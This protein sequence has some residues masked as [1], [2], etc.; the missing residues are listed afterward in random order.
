MR[1]PLF[2]GANTARAFSK[3][4]IHFDFSQSRAYWEQLILSI[5]RTIDSYWFFISSDKLKFCEFCVRFLWRVQRQERGRVCLV[6]PVAAKGSAGRDLARARAWRDA[7]GGDSCD[8]FDELQWIRNRLHLAG[9]A[10]KTT[11]GP[12]WQQDL[13]RGSQVAWHWSR[14]V[15]QRRVAHLT[16]S[17]LWLLKIQDPTA[18]AIVFV[19]WKSLRRKLAEAFTEFEAWKRKKRKRQKAPVF[20]FPFSHGFFP[21]VSNVSK[22]V[23]PSGA[24]CLPR[25]A[26]VGCGVGSQVTGKQMDRPW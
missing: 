7:C 6:S 25:G 12:I 24:I 17:G 21:N 8:W 4:V 23:T 16:T 9:A 15:S 2:S 18:R 11:L 13:P 3:E 1:R 26:V 14:G 10:G 5:L 19:Q 22:F 20:R